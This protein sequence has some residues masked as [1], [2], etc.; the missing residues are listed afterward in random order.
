M[1][2]YT[3]TYLQLPCTKLIKL[4]KCTVDGFTITSVFGD[5]GSKVKVGA[6]FIHL[7]IEY[8]RF[9]HRGL[10]IL[11]VTHQI[12]IISMGECYLMNKWRRDPE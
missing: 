3:S 11:E 4:R 7:I 9:D 1:Y 6:V 8:F 5:E 12:E 10:L 2:L